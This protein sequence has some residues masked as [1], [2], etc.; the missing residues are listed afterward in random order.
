MA[1]SS[2]WLSSNQPVSASMRAGTLGVDQ[3]T[4]QVCELARVTLT[5]DQS[6]DYVAHESC[7]SG[8]PQW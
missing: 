5:G 3:A 4:G 7:Q 2:A 1:A 8:R 6:L